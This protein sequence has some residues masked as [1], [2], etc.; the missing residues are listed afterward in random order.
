MKF[1][2]LSILLASMTVFATSTPV[3]AQVATRCQ[4]Q[5]RANQPSPLGMRTTL[6][7]EEK[8]GDVTFTYK[9]LPTPV[10]ADQPPATIEQSRTMIFYKTTLA[11]AR[12]RMLKDPK[13]FN[14]L[15]GSSDPQSFKP[16]NDLLVCQN[17][18]AQS[19]ATIADLADGSYRMWNGA[20][21]FNVTDQQL[22]DK[23]A[24]TFLFTKTGNRIVGF[25]AR[26]SDDSMC[27]TGTVQGDFI[28][29][30]VNPPARFANP[31]SRQRRAF[32]PAGALR[33]GTW[34]NQGNLGAFS[35]ST[36]DLTNFNRINLG[37]RKA[38]TLCR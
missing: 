22:L 33:L 30:V 18:A 32:D 31:A 6:D 17:Q 28:T 27:I 23:G 37:P 29:G 21:S 2:S 14:E 25:F 10:S 24:Y 11:A 9:N 5:P 12:E 15:R 8:G 20:P 26:P 16:I 13:Y 1:L 36:L 35:P 19:R 3:K 7:V 34:T 4:I 38:P